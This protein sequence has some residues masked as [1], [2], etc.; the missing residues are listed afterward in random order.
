MKRKIASPPNAAEQKHMD[1]LAKMPCLGCGSWA[2]ELHHSLTAKGKRCRRDH[3][4]VIPLCASC[5]RGPSGVHGI[6]ERKFGER[7]GIDLGEW[8]V[9]AWE[10]SSAA[11]DH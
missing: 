9:Q 10:T 8:A 7:I 5:H 6:S 2:I 11:P 4:F 1:R 3:R